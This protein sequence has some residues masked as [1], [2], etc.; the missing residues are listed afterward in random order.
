MRTHQ[1]PSLEWDP[2]KAFC[3]LNLTSAVRDL[4]LRP[5]AELTANTSQFCLATAPHYRTPG[6]VFTIVPLSDPAKSGENR[7]GEQWAAE[8]EARA[9]RT[10][11]RGRRASSL[12]RG[13]T[14]PCRGG[15]GA[16]CAWK[17]RGA[18]LSLVVPARKEVTAAAPKKFGGAHNGARRYRPYAR[19]GR[20]AH[21]RRRR[22]E[23]L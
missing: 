9:L 12:T 10:W 15:D 18:W 23:H 13:F 5:Q 2:R 17:N 19:A 16:V 21:A 11:D 3:P 1:K 8:G 20:P 7:K 14:L 4:K 6:G 22:K